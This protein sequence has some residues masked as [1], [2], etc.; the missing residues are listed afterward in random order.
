MY[1]T[2]NLLMTMTLHLQQMITLKI[3]QLKMLLFRGEATVKFLCALIIL[4]EEENA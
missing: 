1:Y 4:M 2:N 3:R